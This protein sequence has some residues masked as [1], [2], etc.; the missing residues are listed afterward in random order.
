MNPSVL[1]AMDWRSIK[2]TWSSGWQDLL[3]SGVAKY[4]AQ[5]RANPEGFRAVVEGFLQDLEAIRQN[6]ARIAQVRAR[7]AK[8]GTPLSAEQER[9]LRMLIAKY[10]VLASG[11]FAE[12]RAQDGQVQGA[13]PPIPL[14][15]AIGVV[16]IG[17]AG[18]IWAIAAVHEAKNA[19]EQTAFYAQKSEQIY[20]QVQAGKLPPEALTQLQLPEPAPSQGGGGMGWLIG[21]GVVGLT[22]AAGFGAWKLGLLGGGK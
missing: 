20:A 21:L 22:G 12:A 7:L 11:I 3:D 2:S 16:V 17:V 18:I 19:R 8:A 4:G 1:T 13:P 15:L 14:V 10:K 9:L 5:V 6:L